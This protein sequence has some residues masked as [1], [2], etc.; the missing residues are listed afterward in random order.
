MTT[1]LE[2]GIALGGANVNAAVVRRLPPA[3]TSAA[4]SSTGGARQTLSLS[5]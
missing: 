5:T 3:C 4:I 2:P 1:L